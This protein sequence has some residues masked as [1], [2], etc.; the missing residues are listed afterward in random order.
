MSRHG[1]KGPHGGM[2]GGAKAKDFKGSLKKLV[3][4]MS[5]YKVQMLFVAVFAVC[6]T[7]FNIVGPK[8]LGKATTE[9]F[10]GLVSKVSGGS[11]MDFGKIGQILLITLGLYVVSALCSFIQGMIM[12]GISQKTTYRLRKD[13]TE[14]VNR[15]P[16]DY[17]DTKPV[18]EVLSRVTNDVDTL[19]QSLNQ[20]ATQLITSVT[21]LIGVLVMMLSI[22]PLM[23]V[24]ALLIL[25]ISVGLISFVMKHSQKYFSGQQEYLGNVNGQVEEVYSGHNVIKAFNKEDDVIR[26]F[27]RTNDKLYESAWKSQFF[28]G[29]MMPVMQFVG[30]LGYVGVAI[31][32]G[33]LAIK[34]TIE[35]GDIQSFIQYVRNFTQPIQQ[36]AQVTNMLQLAAASSERVFEFLEE[37]EEDQTV[38]HPVSVEGLHGNVQ[39]ENVHFGYNPEKI[40]INDFSANVKEG[41]KI[42]IVGPTGAGKTTMIKLLMRFY[43][44]NSGSIKIDGHDVRD[45]NRSELREM[46]GMVLQDTW[47]FHGTIMDNIR[48]G[49]LDATEEEVIQAAKAAHVHRFVQTLPGGYQMEINEE[50]TN[51]SQ[52]QK[53]LLTI[54]RAILAD[55]KILILDEATSSVDTRTEVR[56]QKAMDNL[57]KGRTSIVIAHRLSTIRDA[58]LI[59]VMKDGDIIEQGTHTQLL[60]QNGFYAELYNSQFESTD[61]TCA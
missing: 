5:V 37:K 2:R 45:F 18:G 20:S 60:A 25:P 58:D 6:G 43:D 46:F 31:L 51:I 23:T 11:G 57:M 61:Q 35:V 36:V 1:M 44:V 17:F 38:E 48:Y 56:I 10:N 50:A 13:I 49:K 26:E 16:M 8:I 52:G 33:F 22:S 55:P 21:T 40:I 47:L 28:S 3:K 14:K 12:T 29:M 53:Q 19:G 30:N 42:A 9:I 4:Y 59:L 15:M 54:A 7:V 41:Q 24:V 32:G 27:D 34:K 39:F